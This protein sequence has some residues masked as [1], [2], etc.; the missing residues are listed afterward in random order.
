MFPTS[1]IQGDYRPDDGGYNHLWNVGQFLPDYTTTSQ[2]TATFK[3]PFYL[4]CV[5]YR[6]AYRNKWATQG[7]RCAANFY[8]KLYIRTL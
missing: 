8:N 7:F 5:W 6:T 2:K 3:V 1:I 4:H